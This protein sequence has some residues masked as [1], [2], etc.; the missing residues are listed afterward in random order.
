MSYDDFYKYYNNIVGKNAFLSFFE[1]VYDGFMSATQVPQQWLYTNPNKAK[2]G[3]QHAVNI[4]SRV[5]SPV[6]AAG[7][8]AYAGAKA[9]KDKLIPTEK[10]L[11]KKATEIRNSYKFPL[12]ETQDNDNW[13]LKK[14]KIITTEM[15][16]VLING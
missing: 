3:G 7:V 14:A 10:E 4:A 2:S 16:K 15:R 9:L 5:F 12:Q 13:E 6:I 1:N 8:G 11:K